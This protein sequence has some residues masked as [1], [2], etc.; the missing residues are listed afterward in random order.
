MKHYYKHFTPINSFNSYNNSGV[1][2]I[3]PFLYLLLPLFRQLYNLAKATQPADAKALGFLIQMKTCVDGQEPMKTNITN[4]KK[5]LKEFLELKNLIT[6]IIN[7]MKE[8]KTRRE[9]TEPRIIKIENQ[10]KE[11]TQHIAKRERKL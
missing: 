3:L 1:D 6:E 4:L 7:S 10:G 11:I 2:T 9:S 8:L 5:N